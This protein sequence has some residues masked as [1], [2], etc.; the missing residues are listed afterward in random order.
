VSLARR[1]KGAAGDR[2]F[3]TN[4]WAEFW[5]RKER[6]KEEE[7]GGDFGSRVWG[8]ERNFSDLIW[9]LGFGG[10]RREESCP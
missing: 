4:F 5:G 2:N 6:K 1:R 3:S 9:G 8:K 10:G 7:Y